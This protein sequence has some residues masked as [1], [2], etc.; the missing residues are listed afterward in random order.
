MTAIP[1]AHAASPLDIIVTAEQGG[2]LVTLCGQIDERSRLS[3]AT[4]ALEGRVILDTERVSFINSVGV[5]HWIRMVRDLVERETTVVLRRCSE[6][7]VHQMNMIIEA[8]SG[9]SVESFF[10]PYECS[11][12]GYEVSMCIDLTTHAEALGRQEAPVLACPDCTGPLIFTDLPERYFL[13]L[14]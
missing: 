10:A 7:V 6:A 13:F 9:S 5:R 3:E 11:R 1:Q 4:G 12:C 14:N 2:H 8:R